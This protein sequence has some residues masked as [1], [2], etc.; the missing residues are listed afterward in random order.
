MMASAAVPG[1][2]AVV[3]AAGLL[4]P[5]DDALIARME[6]GEPIPISLLF[7]TYVC[8][9]VHSIFGNLVCALFSTAACWVQSWSC[10]TRP[11]D[12]LFLLT[13]YTA[14][15]TSGH[16]YPDVSVDGAPAVWAWRECVRMRVCVCVCVCVCGRYFYNGRM[17]PTSG[18]HAPSLSPT[19]SSLHVWWHPT[20]S[21]IPVIATTAADVC[22]LLCAV[23]IFDGQ[24]RGCTSTE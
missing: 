22:V 20:G 24:I 14:A 15:L 4:S 1:V 11:L 2:P 12:S 18:T 6:K 17:A 5:P 13:V 10:V 16:I 3:D 21:C 7:R 19:P 9:A 23:R 8:C